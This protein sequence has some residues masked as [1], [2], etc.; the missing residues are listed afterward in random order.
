M[1]VKKEEKK[2]KKKKRINKC[3]YD[4]KFEEHISVEGNKTGNYKTL[5][6]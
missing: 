4:R 3:E 1:D 2:K 5:Y 6:R